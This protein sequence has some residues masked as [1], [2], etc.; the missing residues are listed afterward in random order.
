MNFGNTWQC[1]LMYS[2]SVF[3][4]IYYSQRET[5]EQAPWNRQQS[6]DQ[7]E[8]GWVGIK[9]QQDTINGKWDD[10]YCKYSIHI[11]NCIRLTEIIYG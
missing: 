8:W 2:G 11:E 10:I 6:G 9:Q 3:G 7:K 4:E 5:Q 1:R